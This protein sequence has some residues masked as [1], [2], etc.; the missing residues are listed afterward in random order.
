M[1]TGAQER[2]DSRA[3]RAELAGFVLYAQ[4]IVEL[5]SGDIHQHEVLLRLLKGKRHVGPTY[6]LAA[7]ERYGMA[8]EIDR[9]VITEAISMLERDGAGILDVNLSG[10]SIGDSELLHLI[11]AELSRSSIEPS[12]LVVEVTETAAIGSMASAIEFSEAVKSF[13]CGLALDDFGVGF[14]SLYYLK[15]LPFDYVKID[16]EFVRNL[17]SSTRDRAMV[18]GIVSLA[19]GLGMTTIAEFVGDASTVDVLLE[20]GVNRGQGYHL[21][22]PAPTLTAPMSAAHSNGSAP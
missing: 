15:H 12:R 5:E 16:G 21:G 10:S 11:E 9:V 2:L 14:G 6:F 18:E 20:L 8:Q 13:G 7:A 17:T 19:D 22:E 3:L 1:E 4:P